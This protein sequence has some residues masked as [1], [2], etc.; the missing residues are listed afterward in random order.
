MSCRVVVLSCD[1]G[2]GGGLVLEREGASR[3]LTGCLTCRERVLVTYW[4]EL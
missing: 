4:R 3:T 2:D 1:G